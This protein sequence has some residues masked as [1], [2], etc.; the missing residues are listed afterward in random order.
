MLSETAEPTDQ[1]AAPA[2]IDRRQNILAASQRLFAR[3][4]YHGVT[5][6]QIAEE[7]H[8]PLA[9]VGYYGQKQ[10]LYDAVLGTG[11][12]WFANASPICRLRWRRRVVM[13]SP[14]CRCAGIAVGATAR[15][16]EGRSYALLVTRGLSQQGTGRRS[17]DPR[18][19]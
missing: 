10:E 12:V 15:N 17:R 4:G 6:R 1:S 18:I 9:L 8:V 5:I 2:R 16:P 13:V 14:H 11:A 3:L 19:L 7:A